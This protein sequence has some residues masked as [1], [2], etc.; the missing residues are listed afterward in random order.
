MSLGSLSSAT[1]PP[2]VGPVD[3]AL[4]SVRAGLAAV[5]IFHGG[6][7]LFGL[8]GGQGMAQLV[9]NLGP[10]LGYLVAIG[11]FFGGLGLLVGFLSRFSAA[12]L[13]VIMAGAIA[14]VHGKNGFS[15]QGGG[16]EYNLALLTMAL[17]ILLAGPGRIAFTQLLPPAVRRF[18]A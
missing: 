11:E 18:L 2:L 9:Q 6:Q 4:L 7:K 5:F 12:S 15:A 14:L 10:V 8:F 13:V 1:R 3:L 17:A 16:Y